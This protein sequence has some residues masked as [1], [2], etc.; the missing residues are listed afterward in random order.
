MR[1]VFQPYFPFF[2]AYVSDLCYTSSVKVPDEGD[3]D[4]RKERC[5]RL[6]VSRVTIVSDND[7]YKFRPDGTPWKPGQEGA[8]ALAQR[9]GIA[10]RI[11]TPPKKDLREWYYAGLTAE[12]FCMVADLQPWRRAQG[13]GSVLFPPSAPKTPTIPHTLNQ[14]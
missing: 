8:R 6:L 4:A 2:L 12:T 14:G 13:G 3:A 11:V 7:E 10:Y 5:A 9:L 1:A